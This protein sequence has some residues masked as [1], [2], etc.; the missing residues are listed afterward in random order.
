M[1][2]PNLPFTQTTACPSSSAHCFRDP[3]CH[4]FTARLKFSHFR[5]DPPRQFCPQL[6]R[7]DLG[8]ACSAMTSASLAQ[9][10]A[11]LSIRPWVR[12]SLPLPLLPFSPTPRQT[13]PWR[14]RN[15]A[16]LPPLVVSCVWLYIPSGRPG[17]P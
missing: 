1:C 5:V 3:T 13:P 10:Q 6:P 16:A 17:E 12:R 9:I 14:E 2:G 7:R 4:P 8:G 15:Q 11:S